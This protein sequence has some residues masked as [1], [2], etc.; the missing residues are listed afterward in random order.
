[1]EMVSVIENISVQSPGERL[2][3]LLAV[4][5]AAAAMYYANAANT[6]A[7]H[8]E[9]SDQEVL[10]LLKNLH[11]DKVKYM[12]VGGFATTF[13]GYIRTTD[14]LDLWIKSGDANRKR[15]IKAL[16]KAGVAGAELLKDMPLVPGWTEIRFGSKGFRLD[17]MENLKA[18]TAEDFDTCYKR[19]QQGE[20]RGVPIRVIHLDD[21]LQDKL[22]TNRAKDREDVKNLKKIEQQ[23]RKNPGA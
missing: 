20:F 12:L 1:M 3:L 6:T 18:F 5:R 23:K 13:H 8:M 14:D 22:A 10:D 16:K 2:S 11:Q 19:S 15:L 21:L 17:M 4:N 7:I 9:I